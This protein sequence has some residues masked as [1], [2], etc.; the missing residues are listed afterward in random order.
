MK[1][2]QQA[3]QVEIFIPCFMDQVYPETGFNMV[4]ILDKLG[5]KV[6][7]FS[8]Q[9]CCGQPAYNAGFFDDAKEVA[10]KFLND[11]SANE[12][13]IVGP[14]ASCVGMLRNSYEHFFVGN[15][16][17]PLFRKF[18]ARVFE[19]T[20]FLLQVLEVD[21]VP[22]AELK[23]IATY[24]DSCSALR[25]CGIKEGPRQ[26]LSHVKGLKLVEMA[27]TE[28]CCGFGG[29]FAVKFEQISTGMAAQKTDNATDTGADFLISTDSSCLLQLDGYT[30][31][32]NKAIKPMHI[33]D[34]LASGW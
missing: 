20:E 19:F 5:C 8:N 14:T 23:G 4:K 27:D 24:H 33:V 16:H 28:T 12:R 13:Y 17:E 34:V 7:Y 29:T 31:K 18:Q 15:E 10:L 26:L 3:L 9:T 22:G 21:A 32:H 1:N 2:A 11:F 30:R 25:E 6:H